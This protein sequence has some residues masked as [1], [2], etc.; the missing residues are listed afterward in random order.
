MHRLTWTYSLWP[1]VPGQQIERHQK[2]TGWN[3]ITRHQGK[4]WRTA[5]SQTEVLAETIFPLLSSSL[6]EPAGRCRIWDSINLANIVCPMLM[7]PTQFSG[8]PQ[9]FPVAFPYELLALA[10]ASDFPKFSQ[11]NSIW[12]QWAPYFSLSCSR[13]GNSSNWPLFTAWPL[14]GTSKQPSA[15][16]FLANAVCDPGQN[17]VTGWPWMCQ[18]QSRL[19]CKRRV[20]IARTLSTPWIPSLGNRGC[21]TGPY[22]TSTTHSHSIKPGKC[23]SST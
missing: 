15:V 21:A 7:I 1:P 13:P 14:L 22:K 6:T 2:Y 20:Y 12:L 17:T 11:T 19:N 9:L 3:W 10:Y 5:F 8:P 4:S 23:S 18:Q 16:C